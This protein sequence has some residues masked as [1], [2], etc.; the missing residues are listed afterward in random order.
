MSRQPGCP[1]ALITVAL[2]VAAGTAVSQTPP[3]TA[4][5]IVQRHQPAQAPAGD[6]MVARLQVP[7]GFVVSLFAG[8]LGKP[9]MM[10]VGP[11]GT[12]YVTRRGDDDVLALRDVDGDGRADTRAVVAR[13]TGVHGVAVQ[14]GSLYLASSTTVWRMPLAS[15]APPVVV[16]D[17]LPD[18][19]Q[20]PNRMVR[21]APDGAML[22]SVG[23][24]CNDCAEENQL[25]R[26]TL[27][28]YAA[29]GSARKVVAKGLRNTIG[30]DWHPATGALW[31]IDNGVDFRGDAV[32]PEELNLIEDGMNYG[33]PVCYADRV[34]DPL[35]NAPPER[36]ALEPGQS[37][38][39]GVRMTRE[40]YCAQTAGPRLLAPAHAAPIAMRFNR[41]DGLSPALRNDAFVAFRGS[42]N[43]GRP[44]G[45]KVARIVFDGAGQP[46]R[47]EDFLT[48]FLS[49]DDDAVLGRPVGIAFAADGALLVSDD[50]NGAIYRVA[51]TR[52]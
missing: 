23:S 30:Y 21:F 22:V 36:L 3:E 28:R 2:A 8:G 27:I 52:R 42:W 47:F 31:G 45:Y 44:S 25:E 37:K 14:G 17:G 12:V 38:P 33:W 10:D 13:L 35:T 19:G 5:A 9:R 29:D 34:V 32:P 7:P 26:G 24:S 39:S 6:A 1:T 15:A 50:T 4:R 49:R 43:R 46:Q 11:D 48:G 41:G 51:R 20:H 18:G 40:A 16:V